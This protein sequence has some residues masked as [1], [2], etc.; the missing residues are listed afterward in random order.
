MNSKVDWSCNHKYGIDHITGKVIDDIV[1]KLNTCRMFIDYAKIG[2]GSSNG[3]GT[4]F[5]KV[6][7]KLLSV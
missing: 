1:E 4:A 5:S 2:I 3:G 6:R 7:L